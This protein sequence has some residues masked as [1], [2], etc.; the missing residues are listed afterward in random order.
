VV[1]NTKNQIKRSFTVLDKNS[2]N[3][4][5]TI[6]YF[7]SLN[8]KRQLNMTLETQVLV[9]DRHINVAGLNLLFLGSPTYPFTVASPTTIH[10]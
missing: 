8:I 7:K 6:N 10:I 2:P 1:L 3:M 5:K 4:N 9:W